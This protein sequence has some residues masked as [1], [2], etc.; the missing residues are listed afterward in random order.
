[1]SNEDVSTMR[2]KTKLK[3]QVTLVVCANADGSNKIPCMMIGK[4]KVPACIASRTWCIPY[5]NRKKAWMDQSVSQVWFDTVFVPT[6][7]K[8]TSQP[9][10][11]LL[12]NAP[13]HFERFEKDGIHAEIFLPNC[14]SWRQPCDQG[15]NNALETRYKFLYLRD[16]LSFYILN[17]DKKWL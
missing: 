11:L 12:H 13:G 2:G 16:V 5:Q 1:M 17:E 3:D 10:L 15:I 14:T 9:V 4:S 8:H 6:V 7:R